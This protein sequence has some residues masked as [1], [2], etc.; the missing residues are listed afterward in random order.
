MLLL[1]KR[2]Y[3]EYIYEST[4][5]LLLVVERECF[6][7]SFLDT[8]IFTNVLAKQVPVRFGLG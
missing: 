8:F 1:L 6:F 7:L 3:L 4:V 2:I 5:L